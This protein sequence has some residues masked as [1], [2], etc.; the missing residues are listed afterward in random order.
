MAS[1]AGDDEVVAALRRPHPMVYVAATAGAT[2]MALSVTSL[3]LRAANGPCEEPCERGG[4][5]LT[6]VA[7]GVRLGSIGLGLTALGLQARRNRLAR[8]YEDEEIRERVE[9]F[10]EAL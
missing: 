8:W 2:A 3:A 6:Q 5:S 7:W 1:S 4:P 9:R 10:N